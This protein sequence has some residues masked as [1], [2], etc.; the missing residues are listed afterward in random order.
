MRVVLGVR[1]AFFTRPHPYVQHR[2]VS[3]GDGEE[4]ER[5]EVADALAAESPSGAYSAGAGVALVVVNRPSC[6]RCSC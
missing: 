2:R 5:R 1:G 3:G 6:R 4:A